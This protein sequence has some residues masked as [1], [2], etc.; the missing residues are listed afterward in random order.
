MSEVIASDISSLSLGACWLQKEGETVKIASFNEGV[1]ETIHRSQLYRSLFKIIDQ[2][3]IKRIDVSMHC[4]SVAKIVLNVTKDKENTCIWGS[5]RDGEFLID[6]EYLSESEEGHCS[7]IV[8]NKLIL[9]TIE[10]VSKIDLA[11]KLNEIGVKV[12]SIKKTGDRNFTIT[13]NKGDDLFTIEKELSSLSFS[14]YVD[15]L[16]LERHIGDVAILE[17]LDY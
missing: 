13:L 1:S 10:T 5:F 8:P 3:T 15:L 11:S 6:G 14:K 7:G 2:E 17:N 16:Y 4:S 12:K 9:G